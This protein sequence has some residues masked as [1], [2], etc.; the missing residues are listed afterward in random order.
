MERRYP[1][2]TLKEIMRVTAVRDGKDELEGHEIVL[3]TADGKDIEVMLA[4][5]GSILEDAGQA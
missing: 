4:P 5:D 2:A 1:G 3:E